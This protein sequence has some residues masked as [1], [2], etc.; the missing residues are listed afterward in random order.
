[1]FVPS[2]ATGAAIIPLEQEYNTHSAELSDV[3]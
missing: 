1:M 3:L 2:Q